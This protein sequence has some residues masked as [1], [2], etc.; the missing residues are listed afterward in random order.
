MRMTGAE[1]RLGRWSLSLLLIGAS[2]LLAGLALHRYPISRWLQALAPDGLLDPGTVHFLD[3]LHYLLFVG[4]F[5][6]FLIAARPGLRE[7]LGVA[8]ATA[9]PPAVGGRATRWIPMV[10]FL[11]LALHVLI[12]AR[13]DIGLGDDGARVAWL[14][15][16]L[17]DPRPVWSG[18]WAPGYLYLHALWWLVTRDAIWAG[19]LMSAFACGGTAWILGRS[20]ERNWGAAAGICA[21]GGVTLLPVAVSYGSVPDVCPVF[22]FL[23]V[24]TIA[25]LGRYASSGRRVWLGFAWLA[26]AV[27]SWSRFET[28][29]LIPGILVPLWPKRRVAAW[30][31]F[32]A[33]LPTIVWHSLP[34]LSQGSAP[35]V[36]SAVFHDEWLRSRATASA[37]FTFFGGWW[38]GL[39]PPFAIAGTLGIVR[40]LRSKRGREWL[41]TLILHLCCFVGLVIFTRG[42]SSPRYYVLAGSILAAYTGVW[43]GGIYDQSRVYGLMAVAGVGAALA[44]VPL[45]YPAEQ[46]H[47]WIRR[48]PLLRGVVDRVEQ[49]SAGKDVVWVSDASAY[50]YPCRVKLPITRYH[51][52]SR[53]DSDP[54]LVLSELRSANFATA[55]VRN[56]QNSALLWSALMEHGDREWSATSLESLPGYFLYSMVRRDPPLR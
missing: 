26:L 51:A 42:G 36:V 30:F 28:S 50:F 23:I 4:A 47:L 24:A 45:M 12:G 20:V 11:S 7:V 46:Q 55:C 27:A 14:Q 17:L 9:P 32:A 54:V 5:L 21:A 8:V 19:I 2:C 29:L 43:L 39:T 10:A 33:L 52:M 38:Q 49:V 34:Y 37:V 22:S 41:P 53:S 44:V 6:C 1:R 48:N 18:L 25:A 13:S 56:T 31:G 35:N 15:Q 3:A 16:W 40:A